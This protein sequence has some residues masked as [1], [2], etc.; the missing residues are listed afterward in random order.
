MWNTDGATMWIGWDQVSAASIQAF[1]STEFEELIRELVDVERF[2]RWPAGGTSIEGPSPSG[3]SDGGRDLVIVVSEP[4]SAD[5][6]A[7]LRRWNASVSLVGDLPVGHQRVVSCK[8]G[9]NCVKSARDDARKGGERVLPVLRAG[10]ELLLV[11]SEELPA[12]PPR[13]RD[14]TE[15][16]TK[17]KRKDRAAE[18]PDRDRIRQDLADQ[19]AKHF[20]Q[21]GPSA[22]ALVPRIHVVDGSELARLLRKRTP[23]DGLS[24]QFLDRLGV[25]R[26]SMFMTHAEWATEHQVDRS[27]PQYV[28]D[29][30]RVAQRDQISRFFTDTSDVATLVVRGPPGIGKTRLVLETLERAELQARVQV[31]EDADVFARALEGDLFAGAPTGIFVVDDCPLERVETFEKRF[32]RAQHDAGARAVATRLVMIVPRG[33]SPR[34][35]LNDRIAVVVVAPLDVTAR[36]SLIRNELGSAEHDP[37]VARIDAATQGYPWLAVLVA[38]EVRAGASTPVSTT[39]AARLAIASREQRAEDPECVRRHARALLAVMLADSPHWF[40]VEDETRDQLARAVNLRD[41]HELDA[42]LRACARRGVLRTTRRWY[43]TPAILEREVWR[44]LTAPPDIDGPVGSRVRHHYPGGLDGLLARLE[45]LGLDPGELACEAA[46]LANDL[47]GRLFRVADLASPG[48]GAVLSFCA[49]HAPADTARLVLT[50]VEAADATELKRERTARRPLVRAFVSIARQGADFEQVE[51]A[52]FRLRLAENEAYANNASAAWVW[53]FLPWLDLTGTPYTRCL[54]RLTVRCMTGDTTERLSAVQGL[55]DVLSPFTTVFLD[56][57]QAEPN[58][59]QAGEPQEA[60]QR[61]W[62]LLLECVEAADPEIANAAQRGLVQNLRPAIERGALD[63]LADRVLAAAA[64]LTE[65]HRVTLRQ[66]IDLE[67]TA[68]HGTQGSSHPLW[69]RLEEQT[70]PRSFVQRL[71]DRLTASPGTAFV[72]GEHADQADEALL[73]E[74]LAP[75]TPPLL[76]HLAELETRSASRSGELMIV[77]GRL[78]ESG[79][80]EGPLVE[81]ARTGRGAYLLSTYCF[82]QAEGGRRERVERGVDAWR[83]EPSLAAGVVEVI[84]RIGPDDPWL[85][86]LEAL[87]AR[88]DVR[89]E[90][91]RYLSMGTWPRTS[92]QARRTFYRTLLAAGT[93]GT[94]VVLERMARTKA[95]LE[96]DDIDVLL[97]AISA[98]SRAPLYGGSAWTFHRCG[99]LLLD[100]DRA[101]EVCAAAILAASHEELPGDNVWSLLEDCATMSPG[102]LWRAFEP[103]LTARDPRAGRL[104]IRLAW[105]DVGSKLPPGDVMAWVGTDARR[106]IAMAHLTRVTGEDLPALARALLVRFGAE[107]A[108][109]REL[110]ANFFSTRRAVLSLAGFYAEQR[111]RAERWL[112]ADDAEV[113]VWAARLVAELARQQV[114]EAED[115]ALARRVGT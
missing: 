46:A 51:S 49:A 63:P 108:I 92:A 9:K 2:D 17:P 35:R 14:A 42:L 39:D 20:D 93:A 28:A 87:V 99:R 65:T 79:L 13:G 37:R 43:V 86:T 7:Y 62:A 102:E 59:T 29:A 16:A 30:A 22:A 47:A 3:R 77:A 55:V 21:G 104:L 26:S 12:A 91:V 78:D 71:R 50:A 61:Y 85:A 89:T 105:H 88:G 11:I 111:T 31:A 66:D 24:P 60:L 80:L 70:R 38:R 40:D 115:E 53:L 112:N 67:R 54:A 1:S 106:G 103:L 23:S 58:P 8:T 98:A 33:D 68:A 69:K 110:A 81:R 95:T 75:P 107:S 83:Q 64:V 6:T 96:P 5:A 19:Y 90:A 34:E 27:S 73:R 56:D 74:G 113:R 94:Q 18:G 32:R 44:I 97:E 76:E 114:E 48:A 45:Q 57:R 4:P 109:G 84:A 25:R 72:E 41:R 52:L 36:N 10:G 100:V 82:G 15:G 101:R